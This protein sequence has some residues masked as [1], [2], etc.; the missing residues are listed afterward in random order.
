[1]I[2]EIMDKLLGLLPNLATYSKERR[3]LKDNA[4]RA[5]SHAIDETYLYYRS[6][7]NGKLRN[8]EVE[9]QLSKYWS[10]AAIP[11]RHFDEDLALN[12]EQKSEY[13]VNPDNWDNNRIE[14]TGIALENVRERY[15]GLLRKP[16][17]RKRTSTLKP[18]GKKKEKK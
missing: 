18:A 15:R 7:E 2:I 11:M 16:T 3:E 9:A 14:A 5:I 4:L 6:L 13:W 17:L 10:A 1:M 12:C 8:S